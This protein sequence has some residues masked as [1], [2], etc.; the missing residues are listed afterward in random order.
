MRFLNLGSAASQPQ[1]FEMT[2]KSD[3]KISN[4]YITSDSVQ[5]AVVSFV[6]GKGE[7]C[8]AGVLYMGTDGAGVCV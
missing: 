7:D 8:C 6:D 1:G 4:C 2:I 3:E 5:C